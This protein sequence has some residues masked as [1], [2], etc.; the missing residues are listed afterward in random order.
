MHGMG[1]CLHQRAVVRHWGQ[2]R[3]VW[4]ETSWPSIYHDLDVRLKRRPVGL[5]TQS[6]N[7]AREVDKFDG[8]D[9]PRGIPEL[10]PSY[11]GASVMNCKSQTVLEAMCNATNTPYDQADYR[12]PVPDQWF[13]NLNRSSAFARWQESG[14]PLLVYRP[15]V[16]RPEWRGS[17]ARNA[18][19]ISYAH[20]TASIREEFFVISIADLEPGKE[21]IVGPELIADVEF[22]QGQ[23][24][25]NDLAALFKAAD[26][27]M[28]SSGFAAILA[29]A[30]G[31]AV[32]NVVGGYENPGA[33]QSGERFVPFLSIG[34]VNGGCRCFTSMCRVPCDKKIDLT[35][36]HK[37]LAE[38]I[39]SILPQIEEPFARCRD[40]KTVFRPDAATAMPV[41][42]PQR[43]RVFAPHPLYGRKNTPA[44]RA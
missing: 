12:L 42:A 31:T 4:L 18:D 29:P 39:P 37:K 23:L 28:T 40:Y 21:W 13:H 5:R 30:V 3:D 36:A 20:L 22:H 25:F 34:P 15:L 35:D 11:S 43:A 27:V 2:T 9:I 7:A 16:A 1:D 24:T 17:V 41:G 19:P 8:R 44:E 6:K 26:L 14:K 32:F 33:L 10:R 38:F